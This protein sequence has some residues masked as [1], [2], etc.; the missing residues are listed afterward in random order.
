MFYI[1]LLGFFV[2]EFHDQAS[3]FVLKK[4]NSLLILEFPDVQKFESPQI[5]TMGSAL[6]SAIAFVACLRYLRWDFFVT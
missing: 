1:F 4:I 2:W 3:N 6:Q 5:A